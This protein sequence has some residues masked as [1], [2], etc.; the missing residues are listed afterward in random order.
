MSINYKY[1]LSKNIADIVSL[2]NRY[3]SV[4]IYI[5]IYFRITKQIFILFQEIQYAIQLVNMT[6]INF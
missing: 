3:G 1:I 2:Y 4:K 6:S 5:L